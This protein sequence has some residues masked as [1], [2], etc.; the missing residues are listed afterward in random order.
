MTNKATSPSLTLAIA[1]LWTGLPLLWGVA[2]TI[3]KA[4]ALFT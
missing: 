2:Q 3:R 1:W 4:L